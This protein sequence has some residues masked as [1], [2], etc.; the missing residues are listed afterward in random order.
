MEIDDPDEG[1]WTFCRPLSVL[2]AQIGCRMTVIRLGD[3]SL[4]AYS[5]V[6][7]TAD[8]GRRLDALG[9][10]RHVLAPNRDHH[11]FVPDFR[12]SYPEA[13]FYAARGVQAKL[14]AVAFEQELEHP[15]TVDAWRDCVDTLYFRSSNELHEIV[16]FHRR[17]RTLITAD[18]AFNI[19]E[20][21][22]LLSRLLLRLNDSFRTFGPSRACRWHIRDPRTARTDLDAILDLEPERIVVAHGEVLHAGATAAL[23][24]AYGW[25]GAS[26]AGAHRAGVR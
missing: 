20:S 17:T 24:D 9:P 7:L 13:R 3:G 26:M 1:L 12:A 10:V 11:L 18:L 15:E 21:Q 25:L 8:L 5:P 14:P 19:H 16:L 6:P 2:G 22:G 23:R 4:L